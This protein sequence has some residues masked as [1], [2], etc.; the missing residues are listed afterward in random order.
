MIIVLVANLGAHRIIEQTFAVIRSVLD[1]VTP[2]P[3]I[4][5]RVQALLVAGSITGC[6]T[7]H[8]QAIESISLSIPFS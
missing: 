4:N 8:L 5:C 1:L 2:G 6:T 3:S 7:E